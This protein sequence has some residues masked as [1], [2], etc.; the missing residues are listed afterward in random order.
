MTRDSPAVIK[1]HENGTMSEELYPGSM[2][3]IVK[4]PAVSP[5]I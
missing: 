5:T 1:K 4:G 3:S 2:F